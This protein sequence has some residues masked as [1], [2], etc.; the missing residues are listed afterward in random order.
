MSVTH[1]FVSSN[2]PFRFLDLPPELRNRVYDDLV[3]TEAPLLPSACQ[4]TSR[5]SAAQPD[6]TRVCRQI[7][8]EALPMFY[9][10][11]QFDVHIHR[12]DFAYFIDYMDTIGEHNRKHIK[13]VV[14]QLMDRLTCGNGL[15]DFA[16][17]CASAEGTA[18]MGIS[19]EVDEWNFEHCDHFTSEDE[20]ERVAGREPYMQHTLNAVF[21]VVGLGERAYDKRHKCPSGR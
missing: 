14:L 5:P 17:W 21:D 8:Q 13:I 16:R 2:Q 4:H 19:V 9:G 7:R 3:V 10:L 20:S 18:E 6:I 15:L 1:G 12:C 11:N